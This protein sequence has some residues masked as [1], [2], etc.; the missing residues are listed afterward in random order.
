MDDEFHVRSLISRWLSD[1]G[2][3]CLQA[4]DARRPAH[5]LRD[6]QVHLVTLDITLP[7]R[8]GTELLEE[9]FAICPDVVVLMVTP[10]RKPARRSTSC[11]AGLPGIWSSRSRA[12]N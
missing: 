10:C 11:G 6:R 4:D 2:F 9:I 5:Y 7:G 3:E 12:S 8:S 1:E